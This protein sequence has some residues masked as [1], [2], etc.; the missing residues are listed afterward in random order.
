MEKEVERRKAYISQVEVEV[1]QLM[2]AMHQPPNLAAYI[3]KKFD[4]FY[5]AGNQEPEDTD[6][7]EDCG[8]TEEDYE[9][10]KDLYALVEKESGGG[11]RVSNPTREDFIAAKKMVYNAMRLIDDEIGIFYTAS[12]AMPMEEAKYFDVWEDD[13]K[14]ALVNVARKIAADGTIDAFRVAAREKFFNHSKDMKPYLKRTIMLANDMSLMLGQ[15]KKKTSKK[16]KKGGK[17]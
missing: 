12:A 10:V 14:F 9:E 8:L 15:Q 3:N 13:D 16:K 6:D 2:A 7:Y 4:V 11:V 1:T 5:S 17:K